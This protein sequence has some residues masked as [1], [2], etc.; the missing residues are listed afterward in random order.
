MNSEQRAEARQATE[1]IAELMEI[2]KESLVSR[3]FTATE[4]AHL[5]AEFQRNLHE[6]Q[7]REETRDSLDK[8]QKELMNAVMGGMKSKGFTQ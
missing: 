6:T 4:R 7:A 5:L 3:G 1:A 8:T 2:Y